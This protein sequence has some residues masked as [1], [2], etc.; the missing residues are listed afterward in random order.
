MRRFVI[1]DIHGNYLAL[2]ELLNTINFDYD[3]DMLISL[4]DIV[5]GWPQTFECIELLMKIK[6]LIL[7]KGN[8]DE[9]FINHSKIIL[10]GELFD[11]YWKQQDAII[12][13]SNGG[14][15][16]IKSYE[17]GN[18]HYHIDKHIEF[19][20][21]ALN[22]HIDDDNNLF[23]HA[24]YPIYHK[25]IKG[26][27][28]YLKD[29]LWERTYVHHNVVPYLNKEE[30]FIDK[31]FS[32]VF[33]GHTP[34]INYKYTVEDTERIETIIKSGNIYLIDCGIAFTGKLAVVNIDT[35]EVFYSTKTGDQYYPDYVG[36]N[37]MSYNDNIKYE[38]GRL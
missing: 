26:E 12:W 8:H 33:I 15:D 4:G 18:N 17:I 20:N 16:T 23:I 29:Y 38:K 22:Y 19:L 28:I 9:W 1:G 25:P 36:R 3:N 11:N 21:G 7:I 2:L 35:D 24:G 30:K 5:D 14:Q 13:F 31:N 34:T 27:N 10:S 37:R 6:N 32:K